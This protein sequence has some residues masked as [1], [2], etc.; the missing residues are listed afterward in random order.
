MM[1]GQISPHLYDPAHLNRPL[2]RRRSPL[3]KVVAIAIVLAVVG[4]FVG[5]IKLGLNNIDDRKF[6]AVTAQPNYRS[7]TLEETSRAPG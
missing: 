2:K 6:P 4:G 1:S 5:F 3:R 7:A